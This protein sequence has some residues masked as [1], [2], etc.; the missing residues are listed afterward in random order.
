VYFFFVTSSVWL[1]LLLAGAHCYGQATA[2]VSGTAV[3]P[4]DAII[5]AATVR[6]VSGDFNAE[7]EPDVRG[8]FRFTGLAAGE[9]QLS[10]EVPGFYP[11][12]VRLILTAGENRELPHIPM[13]IPTVSGC[14][15]ASVSLERN[16]ESASI[17]GRLFVRSNGESEPH[18]L[19]GAE[20]RLGSSSARTDAEGRFRFPPLTEGQLTVRGVVIYVS[21]LGWSARLD[22]LIVP[23]SGCTATGHLGI[24][25]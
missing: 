9:Y 4:S 12:R 25:F 20:M 5:V 8:E 14:T 7:A 22:P 21:L 23:A 13:L 16:P 11:T 15:T 17:S 3:D 2:S 18:P 1:S 10:V 19:S 24:L 6:L